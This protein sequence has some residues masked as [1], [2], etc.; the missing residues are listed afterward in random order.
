[1]GQRRTTSSHAPAFQASWSG[2]VTHTIAASDEPLLTQY[3]QEHPWGVD[4]AIDLYE[5]NAALI[6]DAAYIQAFVVDLCEKIQM[7]RYGQPLIVHFGKEERVA[8]YTLVQLIET[9]DI[10]AHFINAKNAVCLN[11]FSCSFYAPVRC[12]TLCQRWFEAQEVHLSVVFRGQAVRPLSQPAS[13]TVPA[14]MQ[15]EAKRR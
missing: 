7:R 8:G 6:R 1:M 5:C 13:S 2:T 4:A 15:E 11:V 14:A 9:S 3:Q 12:A 10:V